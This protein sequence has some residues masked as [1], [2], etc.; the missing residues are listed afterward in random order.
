MLGR[1]GLREV[2]SVR[3]Y[4]MCRRTIFA[5]VQIIYFQTNMTYFL[6][7]CQKVSM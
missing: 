5:F 1:F 7:L 3:N 2:E 6:L 4:K